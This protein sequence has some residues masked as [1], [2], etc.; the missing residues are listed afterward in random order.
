LAE[1]NTIPE[2]NYTI[3][4]GTM[5]V[6]EAGNAV[7]FTGKLDALSEFDVNNITTVVLRNDQAKALDSLAA[8]EFL[9]TEEKY[10]CVSATSGAFTT[11]GTFTASATANLNAFHVRKIVDRMLK[12]NVPTFDGL[13][14]AAWIV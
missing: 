1:T 3:V 4:K 12:N 9:A 8:T 11:N 10:A 2:N 14:K 7:P 5:V 6:T 13:R